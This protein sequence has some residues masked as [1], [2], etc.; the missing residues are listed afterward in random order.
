MVAYHFRFHRVL[1]A[2]GCVVIV[3]TNW[4]PTTIILPIM[5]AHIRPEDAVEILSLVR[6]IP[7]AR[8]PPFN[9]YIIVQ[10]N[11]LEISIRN[12]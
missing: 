8:Y 2:H 6:H 11:V 5:F 12:V 3:Q 10:N 7:A 1:D 4:A 9:L